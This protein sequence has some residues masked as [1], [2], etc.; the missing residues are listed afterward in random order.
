MRNMTNPFEYGGVVGEE[1]FCNRKQEVADLLRAMQNSEKLFLYSERRFGKTSLVRLALQKLPEQEFLGAYVDL[2]PTD[3]E[4]SFAAALA[5]AVTESLSTSAEKLLDTAKRFFGRLVPSLTADE[6]GKPVLKFDLQASA[7]RAPELEEVL[8]APARIAEQSGRRVVV[9]FDEFQQ[10]LEYESDLVERRLRSVIQNHRKVSYLFLGS[11]K[12]VIQKMFLDKARPL[13][14][15]AGH[16]PLKTIGVADWTPFIRKRFVDAGKPISDE[17]IRT[18]VGL[19][20]GHPFYTQ[21][22]CHVLWDRCP[23]SSPVTE[24]AL[25]AAVK[26]LLERESY[27]YTTL[28]DS[29]AANQKK[30]L[31]GLALERGVIKPFSGD[32]TRRYGLRSASNAQRAIEALL[33]RDAIDR[34]NGSFVIADRFFKIWIQRQD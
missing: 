21:H 4:A 27:G 28:W 31:R 3:G 18:L 19:T 7:E 14:R 29:L 15:A 2:W 16:Y 13:Y 25:H 10:I 23:E 33:A 24:D 26:I 22:L 32:F 34:D 30:L 9:V 12:H 11:R 1:A 8:S 6:E 20:E 17:Q 5:K